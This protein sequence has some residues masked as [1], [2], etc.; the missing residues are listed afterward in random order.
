[1]NELA[2]RFE[3]L[4]WVLVMNEHPFHKAKGFIVD[5]NGDRYQVHL[6][7]LGAKIWVGESNLEKL[8]A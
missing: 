5:Y 6:L 4:E 3:I 1:M 7:Q 8:P 2:P